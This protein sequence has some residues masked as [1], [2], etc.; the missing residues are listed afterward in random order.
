MIKKI[1]KISIFSLLLGLLLVFQLAFTKNIGLVKADESNE[2]VRL[3]DSAI[4]VGDLE[5]RNLMGGVTLYK[6]RLKTLYNGIDT[7]VYDESKANYTYSHNT[8]QWVDLPIT[9]QD[10]RVV[11]WS[12][13]SID[14]WASSTVRTTAIDFENKNPGWI[15][16]AAVNGDSFDIKGTKE[17]TKWHV[18]EG[19][20]YQTASGSTP[21]GWRSD[22]TPIVGGASMSSTMYVQV[23][24]ENNKVIR[25]IPVSSVNAAPSATGVSVY[26]KDAKSEF[27]L[28]GY[29]VY[30]GQYDACRISKYT[31]LPFVKGEIKT[32]VNDLTVTKP[33]MTEGST[34][35][36]E[37][38][39]ASKDGSLD[40]LL[41]TGDYVR[42]QYPLL[43][44]WADVPNVLCG[45]GDPVEGTL[46][47]TVLKNGK[48]LGAGSNLPFVKTT[49]PRTVVGFKEDGST[50]LMVCDG[51]GKTSDYEVGMSYYQLGETM[52]LAGCVEA[53]NLDGGGS[54]TLIVRNSYGEFDVI[55]RP[56]DGSERSIGNAIL[57]VM[58]DPGIS[59]DVKN[60]TRNEVVFTKANT[61]F[62]N[63]VTDVKI[64]IDGITADMVDNKAV[65][66][67]LKEDSEYV[68]T[69]TYKVPSK[70][71]PN[72][73]LNGS[74]K[75]DVK[76]KAFEIPGSGI[77][78]E[79]INKNSVKVVKRDTEY[80]SWIKDISIVIDGT[81]YPMGDQKEMTI[82]YLLDDTEY[83]VTINYTVND[84]ESGN[85]YHGSETRKIKTL[86][87]ELPK[88]TDFSLVKEYSNRVSIKY[89]YSDDDEVVTKAVIMCND[90]EYK[91]S[92]KAGAQ[93]INDL[94]LANTEYVLK[95]I[96][97][98]KNGKVLDEIESKEIRVGKGAVTE[99]KHS[100]TY[101]LDGGKLEGAPTEYVEGKGLTSLPTPT[102]E[103]YEFEGW[104]YNGNKVT[105][106]SKNLTED[107]VLTA[108]WKEA[109]KKGGCNLTAVSSYLVTFIVTLSG[110][111]I[112][113]RKRK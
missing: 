23:M 12:K 107:V 10:V 93:L 80:S 105:E 64:T 65:V 3:S 38:Y 36:R 29:T 102:K 5:T 42:C 76:T 104:Y 13:G 49:H 62:A 59:W 85:E 99:I 19:E 32:V 61:E 14:G 69:V 71:D 51:R 33:R 81:D 54:S 75:V 83:E 92:S 89:G 26:T 30:I 63:S 45:F 53:Y 74:Y 94:D 28:T 113:L 98:Y 108:K 106:I 111:V 48:P 41:A 55:N 110:L 66:K 47:A 73:L 112:V 31:S 88:I 95:L 109:K 79:D 22:N 46:P 1:K 90:V 25:S 84:P 6:E 100:I 20:V 37:F 4:R 11:S 17:P 8:V 16:V 58:R 43:G 86:S 40:D 9:N 18:Q 44:E 68:A 91:L 50:V 96:V 103:G 34:I 72:K 82:A 101:E 77:V 56:S 87:F 78:F 67:G 27:D 2:E 21:I 57:F 97:T 7:G 60:T 52:R 70:E 35:Y 24:D 39:I 15:V